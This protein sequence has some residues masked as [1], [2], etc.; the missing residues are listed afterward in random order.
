MHSAPP[1]LVS[2]GRF[3][4]G[5]RIAA[6]LALITLLAALCWWVQVGAETQTLFGLLLAWLSMGVLSAWCWRRQSWPPGR[7]QWDGQAW[8]FERAH[9]GSS[10]QA[11]AVQAVWDGGSA[12][13]LRLQALEEG[14]PRGPAGYAC[15]RARELPAAWHG[16]RCAVH[17]GDTL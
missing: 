10:P 1:V 14:M 11:V 7:L 5:A 9:A 4:W 17:Q 6:A 12:M 15:L 3:V 16:L 8:W 13:C 2:V